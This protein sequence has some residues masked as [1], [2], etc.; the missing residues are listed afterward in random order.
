MHFTW[1]KISESR[2]YF[3][4]LMDKVCLKVLYLKC[5]LAVQLK[6]DYCSNIDFRRYLYRLNFLINN[7]CVISL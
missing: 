7:I 4:K 1:S 5:N 6:S 3:I 2:Y